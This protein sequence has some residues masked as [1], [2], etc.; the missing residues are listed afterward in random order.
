MSP[1]VEFRRR[2]SEE[3]CR[4]LAKVSHVYF[5]IVVNYWC[6]KTCLSEWR[7]GALQTG[8]KPCLRGVI[9]EVSGSTPDLIS[10]VRE[11][12]KSRR[13]PTRYNCR[14]IAGYVWTNT[15][16]RI[17][18]VTND[19]RLQ[20]LTFLIIVHFSTIFCIRYLW[21]WHFLFIFISMISKDVLLTMMRT[22]FATSK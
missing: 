11:L 20:S 14:D 21:V 5:R 12:E 4:I 18:N 10:I 19:I 22:L 6:G 15:R 1:I 7:L 9:G 8:W 3:G 13:F 17:T 2:V 16:C